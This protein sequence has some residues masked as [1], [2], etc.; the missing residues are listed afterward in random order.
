MTGGGGPEASRNRR[1]ELGLDPRRIHRQAPQ[2]A[3]CVLYFERYIE[4]LKST[5]PTH[6]E[7]RSEMQIGPLS[8]LCLNYCVPDPQPAL[9]ASVNLSFSLRPTACDVLISRPPNDFLCFVPLI[10]PLPAL[11]FLGLC[12]VWLPL[13]LSA[14]LSPQKDHPWTL[15]KESP[16]SPSLS[17]CPKTVIVLVP[18]IHHSVVYLLL[19]CLR[20]A[21]GQAPPSS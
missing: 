2:R 11:S 4:P 14:S 1:Q 19:T 16:P 5:L 12:T 8:L 10:F 15:A 13:S 18:C 17:P 3:L 6:P 9:R 20:G 21:G 7:G